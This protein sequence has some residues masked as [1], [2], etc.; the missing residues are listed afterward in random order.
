MFS[1]ITVIGFVAI[2]C[3]MVGLSVVLIVYKFD[4]LEFRRNGKDIIL[5]LEKGG[6][7]K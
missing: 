2:A 1:W 4:S 3:V 6:E 7:N 5:H